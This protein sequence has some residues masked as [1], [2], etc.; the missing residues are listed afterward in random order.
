VPD[1]LG[2][3]LSAGPIGILLVGRGGGS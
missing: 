2:T 3:R 1:A